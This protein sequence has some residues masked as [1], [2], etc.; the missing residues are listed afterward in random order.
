MTIMFLKSYLEANHGILK[1]FG[2]V[3][4]GRE[5]NIGK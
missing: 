2:G 3:E 1:T 4:Y 5:K